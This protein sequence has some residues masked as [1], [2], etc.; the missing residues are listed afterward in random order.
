[1]TQIRI[2]ITV[3]DK[4]ILTMEIHGP[5]KGKEGLITLLEEAIKLAGQIRPE[6]H[7]FSRYGPIARVD[8]D[9]QT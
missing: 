7:G 9:Q 4:G 2:G 1:M 8:P 5:V 3:D 6:L